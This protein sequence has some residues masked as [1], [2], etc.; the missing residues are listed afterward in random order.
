MLRQV[1]SKA[2]VSTFNPLPVLV[3]PRPDPLPKHHPKSRT[4]RWFDS[5]IRLAPIRAARADAGSLNGKE[6]L[7]PVH[8]ETLQKIEKKAKKVM[9]DLPDGLLDI[10]R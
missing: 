7:I 3:R 4:S 6:A 5:A 9:V 1:P 8:S 2:F 10:F